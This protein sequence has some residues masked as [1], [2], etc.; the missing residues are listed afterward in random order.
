MRLLLVEDD[1]LLPTGLLEAFSKSGFEMDHLPAA[2]PALLALSH[3][4]HDLAIVDLG[5]GEM[6]G[7]DLVRELRRRGNRIPLLILTARDGL[8]DRVRGLNEGADDYLVKPFLFPELLARIQ[9]L[10]RRSLSATSSM[11]SVGSLTLNVATRES[12]LNG[13]LFELTGR[14]WDILHL[15]VLSSPA[16]VPKRRIADSLGSWDRE[17]TENAVEINISRL[18]TKLNPTGLSI[19]TVRGIGYRLEF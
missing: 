4:I 18:R 16:V 2:E 19:R 14:E 11:L 15:F 6:D 3:G 8:A 13:S 7:L 17:I 9:A 10:I 5:L 12:F 1:E